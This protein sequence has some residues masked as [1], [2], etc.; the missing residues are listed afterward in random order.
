[1]TSLYVQIDH[2]H[3]LLDIIIIEMAYHPI[4]R[5]VEE[6]IDIYIFCFVY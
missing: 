2:L 5:I 6:I 3:F 1:M 4:A